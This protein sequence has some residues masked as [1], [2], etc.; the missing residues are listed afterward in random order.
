[1]HR[2]GGREVVQPSMMEI[3]N[4]EVKKWSIKL[5]SNLNGVIFTSHTYVNGNNI[6]HQLMSCSIHTKNAVV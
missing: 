3:K 6:S 5:A 4:V 1:M 2:E